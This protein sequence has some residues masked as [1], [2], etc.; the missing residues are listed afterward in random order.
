EL[1]PPMRQAGGARSLAQAR[2]PLLLQLAWNRVC[3]RRSRA[4]SGGGREKVH[5]RGAAALDN[6]ERPHEGCLVLAGEADDDVARQIETLRV[7]GPAE[8]RVGRIAPPHRLQ[9]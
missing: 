1:L 3:R 9:H 7:S 2:A 6:A 5:L 4:G 8:E